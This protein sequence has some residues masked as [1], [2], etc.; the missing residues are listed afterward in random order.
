VIVPQA[1]RLQLP[2]WFHTVLAVLEVVL[3]SG[4]PTQLVLTIIVYLAGVPIYDGPDISLEFFALVS[5][6]DTAVMALL[7]RVFLSLSGETSRDVFIGIRRVRGEI[8]RG[9][10]LVPV[11]FGAVVGIVAGLRAIAPWLHTVTKSPLD[12]YMRNPI[13]AAV[14]F[15]VVVLAGGIREELQRAFILHR[16]AQ[17]IGGI[18][19]GLG[20]FS[21]L[22]GLLHID[23]GVDVALAVGL[24]GVFWGLLYIKRRS[25]VAAMVNHA[26]FNA[27]QVLWQM[28]ARAVGL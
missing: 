3:V 12:A 15:V 21:L 4:I 14:F 1:Q 24:L 16:F 27:T 5:L 13:D 18:W 9:L 26:G 7:I 8:W 20:V 28:L 10:L 17:R 25:A 23:Q 2:D 22:F 11:M 19:V 6:L